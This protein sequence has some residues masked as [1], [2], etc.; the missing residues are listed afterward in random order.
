MSPFT[1]LFL[2]LAGRA[3]KSAVNQFLDS[4]NA[5]DDI[6]EDAPPT[7]TESVWTREDYER[8]LEREAKKLAHEKEMY[9]ISERQHDVRGE[10]FREILDP[11]L[12]LAS[13]VWVF[14]IFMIGVGGS[15]FVFLAVLS[16]HVAVLWNVPRR[17]P[18]ESVMKLV[19]P[20]VVIAVLLGMVIQSA[21]LAELAFL[22]MNLSAL[23]V[24]PEA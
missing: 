17:N 4:R 20:S 19:A 15:V 22:G 7:V 6:H 14:H 18:Y 21:G 23:S 12:R 2:K 9:V 16:S 11:S 10:G 13:A 1:R 5:E 3:T 8:E 24:V